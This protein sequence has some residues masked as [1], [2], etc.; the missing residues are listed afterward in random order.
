MPLLIHDRDRGRGHPNA[1]EAGGHSIPIP[2]DNVFWPFLS[3]FPP[4]LLCEVKF[5]LLTSRL[6][7]ELMGRF[8]GILIAAW[9]H[10][11]GPFFYLVLIAGMRKLVWISYLHLLP[12]SLCISK[13]HL[14]PSLLLLRAPTPYRHSHPSLS[15]SPQIYSPAFQL[16]AR[17]TR[18]NHKKGC[19]KTSSQVLKIQALDTSLYA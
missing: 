10:F 4:I 2:Q 7:T 16:A 13:P 17:G 6:L 11:K 3:L 19:H 12:E 18:N 15:T 9:H 1:A 14:N 8:Q 5:Q